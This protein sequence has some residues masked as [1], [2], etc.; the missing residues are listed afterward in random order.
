[1]LRLVQENAFCV[2]KLLDKVKFIRSLQGFDDTQNSFSFV[3]LFMQ[4]Q[5][6]GYFEKQLHKSP[7]YRKARAAAAEELL[8]TKLELLEEKC[9]LGT[10][11]PS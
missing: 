3:R 1:M 8:A 5:V 9:D 11:S 6:V 7:A 2:S 4:N 10:V